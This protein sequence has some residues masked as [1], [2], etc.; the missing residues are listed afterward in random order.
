MSCQDAHCEAQRDGWVTVLDPEDE[1]HAR[2]MRWIEGDQGRHYIKLRSATAAEWVLAYG[3][4]RGVTDHSGKLAEVLSNTP[5][6]LVVYLFPPG[7]QCFKPHIDREVVFRKETG[8]SQRAGM[9]SRFVATQE[10]Y[11]HANPHDFTE[12]MNET[13]YRAN[14]LRQRG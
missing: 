2:Y 14:V 7:Q 4:S 6:G 3:A 5:P 1:K 13:A 9:G 12:D 8:I 10:G 11:V